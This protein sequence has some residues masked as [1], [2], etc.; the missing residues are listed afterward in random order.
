[1]TEIAFLPDGKSLAYIS[2]DS[3]NKNNTLSLRPLDNDKS[4]Q[5]AELGDD[6]IMHFALAP[7]GKT[8][9]VVQ[10]GWKHDA[11]LITGLR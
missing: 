11:V 6:E 9:A 10:G 2:A 7:D 5:L 4:Q 1:M 3:E 8:F